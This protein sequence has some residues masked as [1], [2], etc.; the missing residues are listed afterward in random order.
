MIFFVTRLFFVTDVHGSTLT[1]KKFLSA[2][3]IYKADVA[4][5]G[6]DITGKQLVTILE[7]G[8]TWRASF[9]GQEYLFHN[10]DELRRFEGKLADQGYYA[11]RTTGKERE[12]LMRDNEKLN[13]VFKEV[14]LGRVR[15]WVELADE[16]LKG[17]NAKVFVQPGNDDTW[18]VDEV[19][20]ASKHMV[21]PWGKKVNIDDHHEMISL[22]YANKTPWDLPRDLPEG[23][24]AQTI[25]G[26]ASQVEDMKNAI[27]NFHAPPYGCPIDLAPELDEN[28]KPKLGASGTF[29][30]IHVGSRAIADAIAKYQ[31]LLGLH[32]HIHESR[33]FCKM[34]RTF[35]VNPGSSYS[36]GLLN[37]VILELSKNKIKS[38]LLTEG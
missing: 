31:P 18:E 29:N 26:L 22:G 17:L 23:E 36:E 21:N 38:Y 1:F 11:Y 3:R 24:L 15:E 27:Y 5:I 10:E 12:E 6:G 8:D 20:A 32:G 25:D 14:I 28:L 35:C 13:R 2:V 19:L 30:F 33:G 9:M 4:I 34:G 7:E 37:G 16:R